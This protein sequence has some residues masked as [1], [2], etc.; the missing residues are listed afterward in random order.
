M[1]EG[2]TKFA[3]LWSVLM[4]GAALG[5][6]ASNASNCA[7]WQQINPSRHDRL[8]RLTEAQILEHNRQG[9]KQGC[10]SAPR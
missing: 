7:G 2:L 3:A 1:G 10:W 6:C 5:G 8:T 4:L 9:E